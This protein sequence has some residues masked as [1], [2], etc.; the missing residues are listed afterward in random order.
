MPSHLPHHLLTEGAKEPLGSKGQI[1]DAQVKAGSRVVVRAS[2]QDLRG[3]LEERNWFRQTGDETMRGIWCSKQYQKKVLV[4]DRSF[5]VIMKGVAKE[6]DSSFTQRKLFN[7]VENAVPTLVSRSKQL[8]D[9]VTMEAN[10]GERGVSPSGSFAAWSTAQGGRNNDRGYWKHYKKFVWETLEG[11]FEE[12]KSHRERRANHGMTSLESVSL[13]LR[14]PTSMVH[15]M[16]DLSGM[17]TEELEKEWPAVTW[18]V[19][20][21]V[22]EYTACMQLEMGGQLSIPQCV[23]DA[24]MQ[25]RRFKLVVSEGS[26]GSVRGPITLSRLLEEKAE[27]M[28]SSI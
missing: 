2:Q 7:V 23:A 14:V 27:V 5:T 1:L 11:F 15:L 28:V 12:A 21:S 25:H 9:P 3:W 22:P 8:W 6:Y 17:L 20:P 19:F 13:R 10:S 26:R 4:S 24:N 16:G 18:A